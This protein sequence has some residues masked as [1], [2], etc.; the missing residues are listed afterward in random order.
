MLLA[1]LAMV[2]TVPVGIYAAARALA[3][4]LA[5]T[6]TTA[7]PDSRAQII[8]F[9][10]AVTPV[11]VSHGGAHMAERNSLGMRTGRWRADAVDIALQP[12]LPRLQGPK[13]D[14]T[15]RKRQ[16]I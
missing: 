13:E 3:T 16:T 8:E 6:F 12:A 14:R 15:A 7:E 9:A 5:S 2:G 1:G 4:A 10:P 11:V